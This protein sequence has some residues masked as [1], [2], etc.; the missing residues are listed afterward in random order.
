METFLDRNWFSYTIFRWWCL[1]ASVDMME[2]YKS[3]VLWYFV[4]WNRAAHK[5]A[6]VKLNVN[7]Y[8]CSKYSESPSAFSNF[9]DW[10]NM[11]DETVWFLDRKLGNGITFCF[12][13]N[14]P[15]S[16]YIFQ[17]INREMRWIPKFNINV[18]WVCNILAC[19]FLHLI[20][21]N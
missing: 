3:V 9:S 19:K 6:L 20:E 11:K 15:I 17:K 4:A 2:Y 13:L 8:V 18:I 7:M 5:S 1:V 21:R 10:S 16:S 12:F 14:Y